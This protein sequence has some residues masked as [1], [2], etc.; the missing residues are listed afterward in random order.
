MRASP[1]PDRRWLRLGATIVLLQLLIGLLSACGRSDLVTT[2]PPPA[3]PTTESADNPD[4]TPTAVPT[5]APAAPDFS[6]TIT[7]GMTQFPDTLF[8]IES[9]SSAT[10]QVLAAIQPAC[11]SSLSYEYQP[12]CFER[13][14][15]FA[16]GDAVTST[17]HVDASYTGSVVIEEELITDT[18]TLAAPVDLPQLQVTFRLVAGLAWEDGTPL[19]A[20]D[21]AFAYDLYKHPN[22]QQAN[23]FVLDRTA[24]VKVLDER[25]FVWVGLPGYRDSTY[26]LNYFGPEPAHVLGALNPAE[27]G[28]S[29]YASHPLAYGPYKVVAN[30]PQESTT[31]VAN[32]FYWRA[33][34]GLPRVGNIVF[35]YLTS[36]GQVLE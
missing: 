31:L 1:P 35:K 20:A 30:V 25:T 34:Q 27:I 12:V 26:F 8:D 16:N 19:T 33:D 24:E 22:V 15:S 2:T 18:S 11:I 17:V 21:F 10:T 6:K 36:E 9:R 5:T 7:I 23:R 14:P 29:A 4:P 32:P 28:Y 13:V 3:T